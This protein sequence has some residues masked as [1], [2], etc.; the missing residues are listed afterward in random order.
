[1]NTLLD[2]LSSTQSPHT[3]S[4]HVSRPDLDALRWAL[5]KRR[6][7]S[8]VIDGSEIHDDDGFFAALADAWSFPDW[9]GRN[10]PAVDDCL[11]DLSWLP[12]TGYVTILERAH[13]LASRDP[14]LMADIEKT[15]RSI[16]ELRAETGMD[17]SPEVP[18]HLLLVETF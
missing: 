4:L 3:R 15:F 2:T 6:I 10:W 13:D 5:A 8:R 14:R 9:C 16:G 1:M 12:A 17:G 18:F 11:S 7:E